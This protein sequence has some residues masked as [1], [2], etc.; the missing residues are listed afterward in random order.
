M[1]RERWHRLMS[2]WGTP[3]S[4]DTY[5][6]LLAIYSEPHRRYHTADHIDDCLAQL[7]DTL[8]I[9]EA[10][11]EVELA[12]WFHDAIYDAISSTNEARSAEWASGFLKSAKVDDERSSR[13]ASYILAT[14]HSAEPKSGDAALVV[15]IDLS[16]LGRDM[17][18]FEA[19][20]KAIREEYKWVPMLIYR[21]KRVEILQSF[22]DR[23]AIYQTGH[24]RE[25][26]EQ[27][28]RNN[29]HWAIRDL[30]Q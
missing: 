14:R 9:A 17:P 25:R 6:K 30:Q 27:Q 1:T 24:F 28:A 20:E 23:P 5:F 13:V 8:S 18:E 3:A 21:R 12:L 2:Q 26:F 10:P 15:D 16:I 22:L 4:D 7:D 19:Y 29:L 11:E